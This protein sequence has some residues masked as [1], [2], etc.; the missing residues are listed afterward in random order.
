MASFGM[1]R[2][3]F[4][5]LTGASTLA[6]SFGA[7]GFSNT[8]AEAS[9]KVVRSWDYG[10]W[11]DLFRE[12]WTWDSVTYGTHLA[13]C[14]PG[15]CSFR[16]YAK[17]G[18]VFRE[19]QSGI[20]P[21]I[22]SEGPDW[23]P[24]GCNKGCSYSHNMYNPD[25]VHFPMRRVGERGEGKWKRISWDE[26]IS[27]I[28]KHIVD[29]LESEGPNSIIYEPGPGN[30]GWLNLLPSMR[31]ASSVGATQLDPDGTIGDFCKGIYETFG[32]FQFVQSCDS[33]YFAKLL[34]I[35]HSNP[36]YTMIPSSHFI[37]EA[38]YNGA[39]IITI[40]PDYSPSSI[41]ADEWVPIKPG[42]DAALALGMV[43]VLIENDTVD[44]PF[45]KEQTD[46]PFLIRMDTDRFLR[47]SDMEE[48]GL[49][50]QF[51]MHDSA[52][53]EVVKA[54]RATL[55][56]SVDPDLEGRFEVRLKDGS[57]VEVRPSF[58]I[59]KEKLN[60]E[61]TPENAS[62]H[63][64]VPASTI[65]RLAE[66]AGA[67]LGHITLLQGANAAKY[68][69]GDLI[70]RGFCLIV[71]FTGSLGKRGTGIAGWNV[72]LF[73]GAT[74]MM[75]SDEEIRKRALEAEEPG[76]PTL[77]DEMKALV[78]ERKM[79]R[80][81]KVSVPPV[82]LYY[83]HSGY[84]ETWNKSEW[85]DPDMKRPFDSYMQE[86]LDKGW[87]EGVVQ[88][89]PDQPPQVYFFQGT[90]PARKN[91][92]WRKNMLPSFWAKLKFIFAVE[93]RFSTSALYSDLI[94]PAAGF[95]EKS[96]TRFPTAHVPFLTLTEPAVK[97]PGEA[98]AEW[99][100]WNM[101]AA[102]VGEEAESRGNTS[103]LTRDGRTIDVSNLGQKQKGNLK[104]VED[105]LDKA[106]R[107][108]GMLGTLPKTASLDKLKKEG[109]VRF[110]NISKFDIGS[111]NVATDI[112]PDEPI[113]S[114]T[115]HTGPKKQPYP[116]LTRRIQFYIDH[117]WFMEG[118]E[119]H[120]V[121]KDNPKMGGDYPMTLTSGHQ[122]WS[123]HSINVTDTRLLRTH[124]G[125]PFAFMNT[126]DAKK[127][128]IADGD[129]IRVYNDFDDFKI[130]V[131]VTPSAMPG[132]G[133]QLGQLIVYHAW[134]PFQFDGWKS[135]DAII[136]GMIKW[137]D[138][139]GGYGHLNYYRSNW[140]T[141]PVDRAVAI[142]VEKAVV[143]A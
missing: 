94:L 7:L 56:L 96:D 36:T 95:Y 88:P 44:W 109:I 54:D 82:F 127:R 58:S 12:E 119:A 40:A 135:Y 116:T 124:Q 21:V 3:E 26:A 107:V 70:E 140:C 51:Y 110:T 118:G 105:A 76:D 90:S 120:P 49:D 85:H 46:F 11:E 106:L 4:L 1:N 130:H 78:R 34:F 111:M 5:Q 132:K 38:R 117:E 98:L 99:D 27:E 8:N 74:M 133:T 72:S 123:V 77:T 22:D 89:A 23:N 9:E 125:R 108:S 138:L 143:D 71:A 115:Y 139:A 128:G 63:C 113:I 97:P 41:H 87:W 100:T 6:L 35:W 18:V 32:K 62:P 57:V 61:Y 114:L 112:K 66:K 50:D 37:N 52:T 91:R 68:Y 55:K 81:G 45:I 73:D 141:Q 14:Y 25:R 60:R 47:G 122:R 137:N 86:A 80:E 101:I 30:S 39:E 79:A 126:E 64:G 33:W 15:N 142:E 53:G 31:F 83:F 43:Q 131:K 28:A 29:A 10:T 104:S 92:G 2:R 59:F 19:E 24:R 65:R 136:P 103:F 16:V 134:E 48:G 102:K 129:L 69:H 42:S 121:H 20:Y 17:E 84:K 75:V 93:T 67:N 13:D